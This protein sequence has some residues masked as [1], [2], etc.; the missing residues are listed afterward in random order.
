MFPPTINAA[1]TSEMTAPK[2]AMIAASSGSRAS[3][4]TASS[5]RQRPAPIACIW[6][7]KSGSTLCSPAA[8]KPA[9]SGSAIAVCAITI[10]VGV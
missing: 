4:A 9:T 8:D 1:P 7:R 3:A 6:I 5:D 2:P 10:A